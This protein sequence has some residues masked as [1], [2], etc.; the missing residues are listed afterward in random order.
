M[1]KNWKQNWNIMRAAFAV[2]AMIGWWSLLYPELMFTQSTVRIVY[3]KA[4]QDQNL[5]QAGEQTQ[6]TQQIQQ[7]SPD[8]LWRAI[9]AAP[10][11]SVRIK[12][13]FLIELQKLL[14]AIQN[15][16]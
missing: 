15:A 11:G 7:I 6:Q 12:S 3:E 16:D 4:P 14:E 10:K 8:S 1:K 2:T 13:K 5:G 9:L